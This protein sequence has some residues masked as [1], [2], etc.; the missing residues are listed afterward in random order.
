MSEK[1]EKLLPFHYPLK[2]PKPVKKSLD[3]SGQV[4]KEDQEG[5]PP[6]D[7]SISSFAGHIREEKKEGP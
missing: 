3:E 6:Q 4:R 5:D 7:G 1:I 2:G